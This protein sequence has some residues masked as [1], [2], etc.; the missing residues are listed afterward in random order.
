M[1]AYLGPTKVSVKISGLSPGQHAFHLVRRSVVNTS[2]AMRGGDFSR[3]PKECDCGK[4][5][6]DEQSSKSGA[7]GGSL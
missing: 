4:S 1:A 2:F 3:M 6:E 5:I 7:A